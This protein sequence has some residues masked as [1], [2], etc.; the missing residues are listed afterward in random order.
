M[1]FS[2]LRALWIHTVHQSTRK[3]V[4]PVSKSDAGFLKA[5]FVNEPHSIAA[6]AV[7]AATSS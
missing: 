3:L 5:E 7:P 4:G 1:Q 6:E 2:G